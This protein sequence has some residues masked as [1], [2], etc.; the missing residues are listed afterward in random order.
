MKRLSKILLPIM[1]LAA[2]LTVNAQRRVTP[3]N[4]PATATQHINEN[5]AKGD[6]IDRSRLVEMTDSHGNTILVDTITG[7]EFVDTT[8]TERKVPKMI[9]PLLHSASVSFDLFTPAT[10]A[11][12]TK[13]GLGE[14]AAELN[15]HN[16]YIPVVEIGLGQANNTPEDNNYTYRT[17][18][19]PFFRIGMNYNFL[20]QSN[21]DYLIMAGIRY[22]FTPFRF[23]VTDITQLPGYWDE[24]MTYSIPSQNVTAGYFQ[25]LL[26]LR[27]RVVD[28]ISLGWSVRYQSLLHDTDTQYGNAWY[29]PGYGPRNRSI[30]ATFSISYS[31]SLTKF[32]KPS[33]D[34]VRTIDALGDP[35]TAPTSESIE[36]PETDTETDT[37]G[38][39][40][41]DSDNQ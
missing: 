28:N 14:I 38:T 7:T 5:K 21:P 20:Y 26:A 34:T 11:F 4:T 39:S 1:A 40:E 6:S 37:A 31:V 33:D 27:V 36:I 32:N 25:I 3:V 10:R 30:N 35:A 12:G 23:E 13:Y 16:R 18:V 22:G 9:Y 19:A 41:S 17:P 8:A 29:I 2:V 15:L 24:P